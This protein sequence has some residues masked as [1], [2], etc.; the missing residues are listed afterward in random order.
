MENKIVEQN[1]SVNEIDKAVK[2]NYEAGLRV[3][4][5]NVENAKKIIDYKLKNRTRISNAVNKDLWKDFKEYSET[6]GK[7]LSKMLDAAIKMYLEA[8]KEN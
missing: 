1:V 5:S 4:T 7:P 2:E 3:V 8:N 6:S